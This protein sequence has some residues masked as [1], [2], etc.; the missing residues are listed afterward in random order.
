MPF[1]SC[2]YPEWFYSRDVLMNK[3][4]IVVPQAVSPHIKLLPCGIMLCDRLEP[5]QGEICKNPRP[6]AFFMPSRRYAP[7]KVCP[8]VTDWKNPVSF[9]GML[10]S[11][12][13]CGLVSIN[14][15][16]KIKILNSIFLKVLLFSYKWYQ[17]D[18]WDINMY[19][20]NLSLFLEGHSQAKD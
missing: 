6:R 3:D 19:V 8:R 4:S 12:H 2:S 15:D 9:R 5:H 13:R 18:V 11:T 17:Y 1:S 16:K 7:S 14:S 20:G 10:A